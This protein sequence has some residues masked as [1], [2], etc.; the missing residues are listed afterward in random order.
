VV[1]SAK[2][3]SSGSRLG[4]PGTPLLSSAFSG[5]FSKRIPPRHHPERWP[6]TPFY[7][8]LKSNIRSPEIGN[9]IPEG[10]DGGAEPITKRWLATDLTTDPKV[11]KKIDKFFNKHQVTQVGMSDGNMGCQDEEGE[12]FPVGDDCP[13]F[14]LVEG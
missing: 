7:V 3:G 14:P 13:Y 6:A 9:R 12:D 10:L 2:Y 8:K 1:V 4:R 5:L 11:R